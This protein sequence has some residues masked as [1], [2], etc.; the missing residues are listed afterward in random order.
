MSV[1]SLEPENWIWSIPRPAKQQYRDAFRMGRLH[2]S[3]GEAVAD[4]QRKQDLAQRAGELG[5]ELVAMAE[6]VR[7]EGLDPRLAVPIREALAYGR[8]AMNAMQA[9]LEGET[10]GRDGFSALSA[11]T[12]ARLRLTSALLGE[13]ITELEGGDLP[14]TSDDVGSF[15]RAV[16]DCARRIPNLK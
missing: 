13:M 7:E 4:A 6:L 1:R 3:A 12:L 5:A 2:A 11:L 15:C 14:V 10:K 8:E 16:N 9:W